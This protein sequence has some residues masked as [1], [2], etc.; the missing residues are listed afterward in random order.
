ML[1]SLRS[2]KDHGKEGRWDWKKKGEGTE[3]VG[4]NKSITSMN[5]L[6]EPSKVKEKT[7]NI[8][9][10]RREKLQKYYKILC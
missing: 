3:I 5:S 4:T 2:T 6:K 7:G 8:N 10:I 1:D 9:L